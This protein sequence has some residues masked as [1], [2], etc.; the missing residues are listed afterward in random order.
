MNITSTKK[1][2]TGGGGGSTGQ[3]STFV[4]WVWH[5]ENSDIFVTL[6]IMDLTGGICFT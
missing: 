3:G 4:Q 5:F 2:K 1:N 6:N